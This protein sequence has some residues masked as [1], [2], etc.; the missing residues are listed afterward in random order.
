[1]NTHRPAVKGLLQVLFAQQIQGLLFHAAPVAQQPAWEHMRTED[2]SA[3]MGERDN[4][5]TGHAVIFCDPD[6]GS[7]STSLLHARK[8]PPVRRAQLCLQRK[9]PAHAATVEICTHS[10]YARTASFSCCSAMSSCEGAWVGGH[11]SCSSVSRRKSRRESRWARYVFKRVKKKAKKSRHPHVY[12]ATHV[13]VHKNVVLHQY[14]FSVEDLASPHTIFLQY[15]S[16]DSTERKTHAR[17][18]TYT[19]NKSA[20]VTS[21][22]LPPGHHS[23]CRTRC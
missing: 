10:V 8:P 4:G 19:C 15:C 13:H 11:T 3:Y 14:P 5:S 23:T 1:M 17:T 20:P 6:T 22:A 7:L 16:I 2:L 18:H 21:T 12:N 9:R